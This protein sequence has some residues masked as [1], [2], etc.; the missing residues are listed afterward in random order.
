MAFCPRRAKVGVQNGD[1]TKVL[2]NSSFGPILN[3]ESGEKGLSEAEIEVWRPLVDALR[4]AVFE[5][6]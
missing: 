2:S 4:T 5:M 1:V 3:S 6:R